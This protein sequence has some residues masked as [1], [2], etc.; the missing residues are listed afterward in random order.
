MRFSVN[1]P[2]WPDGTPAIHL[3]SPQYVECVDADGKVV[4]RCLCADTETGLVGF[5]GDKIDKTRN[6]P[7]LEWAIRPAPLTLLA[8]PRPKGPDDAD[9]PLMVS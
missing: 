5:V 2:E 9:E 6:V 8:K 7:W 4:D 3:G 1:G